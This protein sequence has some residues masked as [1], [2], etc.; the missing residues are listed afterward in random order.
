MV[1]YCIET[2]VSHS[3]SCQT[4]GLGQL[5]FSLTF[6]ADKFSQVGLT[7]FNSLLA[8]DFN[9]AEGVDCWLKLRSILI[10]CL[11]LTNVYL[12]G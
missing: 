5:S 3:Y 10:T 8:E 7:G 2:S 4:L 9:Y 12:K 6:I 11:W 1:S